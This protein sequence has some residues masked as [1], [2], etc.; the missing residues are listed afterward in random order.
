MDDDAYMSAWFEPRSL[1]V[2]LVETEKNSTIQ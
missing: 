1:W 2:E